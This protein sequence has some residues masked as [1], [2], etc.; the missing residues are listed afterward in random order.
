MLLKY[1]SIVCSYLIGFSNSAQFQSEQKQL[2]F[3]FSTPKAKKASSYLFKSQYKYNISTM[4]L[5]E[6][7]SD[8]SW[9]FLANEVTCLKKKNQYTIPIP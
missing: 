4:R 6:S 7:Y 8:P 2:L 3:P 5:L 9:R 1:L